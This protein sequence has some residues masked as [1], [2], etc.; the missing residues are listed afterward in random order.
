MLT[1]LLLIFIILFIFLL[2]IANKSKRCFIIFNIIIERFKLLIN[3]LDP[4]ACNILDLHRLWVKLPI[5]LIARRCSH[6]VY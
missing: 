5:Q 6:I 2:N 3:D 4:V 1:Q